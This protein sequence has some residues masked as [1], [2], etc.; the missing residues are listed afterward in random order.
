M[1][2]SGI[3]LAY[4]LLSGTILFRVRSDFTMKTEAAGSLKCWCMSTEEHSHQISVTIIS[5]QKPILK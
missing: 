4:T 3:K 2:V 1:F 5:E